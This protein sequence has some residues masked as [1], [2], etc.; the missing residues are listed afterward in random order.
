[1]IREYGIDVQADQMDLTKKLL[2]VEDE[3]CVSLLG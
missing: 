2:S 3:K 1:M